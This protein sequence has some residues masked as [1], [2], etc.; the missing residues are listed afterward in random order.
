MELRRKLLN[1][2]QNIV[3]N[4]TLLVWIQS[5]TI[6]TYTIHN[7]VPQGE[8][9]SVLLFLSTIDD[10]IKCAR[11]L[12]T[13]RPLVDDYNIFLRCSDTPTAVRLLQQTLDAI[14][15]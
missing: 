15:L 8:V 4:W 3:H 7:G 13:R 1:I 5:Q 11:F 12:L 14:S 9:L 2:L 10:I 6:S